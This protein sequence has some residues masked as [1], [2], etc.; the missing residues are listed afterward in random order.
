MK[1]ELKKL[2]IYPRLSE[3]TTA[4]NADV[5]IEGKKV[6]VAKNDGHG[7]MTFV[8][9]VIPRERVATIEAA[10][11]AQVPAEYAKF[12]SGAEWAI[13]QI[14]DDTRNE[15]ETAKQDASIKRGCAK[16]GTGA[17]RFVVP[18]EWGST[19]HWIEYGPGKESTAKADMQK[20]H[21][22][23]QDWTVIVEVAT[24]AHTT[25][26]K[27]PTGR[28]VA[29]TGASLFTVTAT[30]DDGQTATAT[31]AAADAREAQARLMAIQTTMRLAGQRVSYIVTEGKAS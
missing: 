25:R 21:P 8:N 29:F 31:V 17:A 20:Q 24:P 27:L 30:S 2:A 26:H 28:T 4:F 12:T 15:K 13:D 7:G 11:K 23:L 10:L 19:Q 14:V 18:G 6:A 1:L 16:R 5:W 22:T 3:E 9:W